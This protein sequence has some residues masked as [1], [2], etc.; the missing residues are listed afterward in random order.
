MPQT[1]DLLIRGGTVVNHDGT[2]CATSAY[3]TAGSPRSATF[4]RAT[5]RRDDRAAG[6]HILPGVIDTQV[7]FREPGAE[8]KEDLETGS[9]AAVMGGVTAV[10]EM[11]NTNPLTT[12]AEALADKLARAHRPHALRLRLLGR[13]HARE[14]RRHR[15][16]RAAARRRRDQGVHGLVDRRAAGRRTT[17]ACARSCEATRRRAAFHCRGRGR[18]RERKPHARRGRS[19]R[20]HPVWRDAEAALC[21]APSASSRIAR[22][23]GARIHVL[24]ISTAEEMRV[25]RRPQGRRDACEVTPHHLTSRA[26]TTM[27]A[28]ARCRR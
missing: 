3:A 9:R 16:A 5:R 4:P 13:R 12:S 26:P 15:R 22:E 14:C 17:R 10:F 21:A 7:H 23:T 19:R 11:P 18:L 20:S 2:V 24:H 27:R 25:P 6:L 28:S 8:H 1:F